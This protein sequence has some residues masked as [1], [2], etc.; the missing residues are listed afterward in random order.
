MAE[1]LL[2]TVEETAKKLSI[3]KQT[4]YNGVARKSKR[5]FPIKPRRV[6]RCVRF[7]LK[8]VEAFMEG[9]DK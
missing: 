1:N 4:I 7:S 9:I 5:P 3:S 8:D 2:L 6:G